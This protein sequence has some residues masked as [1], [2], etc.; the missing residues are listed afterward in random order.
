M[1]SENEGG[2]DC[3]AKTASIVCVVV[4]KDDVSP[5]ADASVASAKGAEVNKLT[6]EIQ[7]RTTTKFESSPMFVFQI[8]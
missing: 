5:S 1:S 8:R 7:V 6:E 4:D 2:A 3:P